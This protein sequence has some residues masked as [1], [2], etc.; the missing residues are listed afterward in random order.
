M[1]TYDISEMDFENTEKK[2]SK[3]MK[4]MFLLCCS[5]KG[6]G[7]LPHLK[8]WSRDLMRKV[9]NVNSHKDTTLVSYVV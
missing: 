6:R 1:L 9:V 4:K 5:Y 7:I 2:S 3:E 8:T